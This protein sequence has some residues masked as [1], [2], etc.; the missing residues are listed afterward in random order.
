MKTAKEEKPV[1][2]PTK[3]YLDIPGWFD[4]QDIF[5]EAVEKASKD[6]VSMFVEMGAWLGRSTACLAQEIKDSG[7]SIRLFTVD[8]FK[9]VPGDPAFE[10]VL[11]ANNGDVFDAFV[12]NMKD[13]G[14]YGYIIPMQC[15]SQMAATELK[16][17]FG[18]KFLDFVFID[19]AHDYES[20]KTDLISWLPLIKVGGVMAGHDFGMQGVN[21]A[22]EEILPGKYQKYNGRT[23]GTT[24][25]AR[26]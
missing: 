6:K 26:F 17:R 23:S 2:Q 15:T 10:D 3:S 18:E 14:V 20:V 25:I 21:Q 9:G 5:Q 19:G 8:T 11:R 13:C 12:K 1:P 4:Y 16:K 24:W 22:L 7:K